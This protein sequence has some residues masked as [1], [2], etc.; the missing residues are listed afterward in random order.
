M[1]GERTGLSVSDHAVVRFIERVLRFDVNSIRDELRARIQQR[2]P[3][4]I[5]NADVPVSSTM[6]ARIRNGVVITVL[7]IARRPIELAPPPAPQPP[8]SETELPPAT[9]RP[10][11]PGATYAR[12]PHETPPSLPQPPTHWG[13]QEPPADARGSRSRDHR[14]PSDDEGSD[15]ADPR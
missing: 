7:P 11:P 9:A 13:W 1:V 15:A 12:D 10:I 2:L 8:P 3:E 5:R 6:A 14:A 4:G